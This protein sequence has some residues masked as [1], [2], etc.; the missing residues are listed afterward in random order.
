[1][2][3]RGNFFFNAFAALLLVLL[4]GQVIANTITSTMSWVVPSNKSH[5]IAYGGS[6]S[7]SSFFFVESDAN[8]DG[9][10]TDG[11]GS[12]VAPNSFNQGGVSTQCQTGGIAGMTITNNG[13]VAINIDANV[14]P[15]FNGSDQNLVLKVWMGRGDGCTM[16]SGL[17]A[18]WQ[19]NCGVIAAT[20][21]VT[22]AACRDFNKVDANAYGRLTTGLGI[23]GTNQLCF[24]GDFGSATGTQA[25]VGANVGQGTYVHGFDTNAA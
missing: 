10:D 8:F 15:D 14:N 7:A 18:G 4:L 9:A 2:K 22:Q 25:T 12:M 20:S 23:G 24:S 1:M 11:N 6:C 21:P 13:N 19:S 17:Y 3:N 5:S 16:T